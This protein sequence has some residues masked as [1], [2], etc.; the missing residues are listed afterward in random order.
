M[1]APPEYI[2]FPAF[3][4]K[5]NT[6]RLADRDTRPDIRWKTPLSKVL[7]VDCCANRATTV[8]KSNV[9]KL[10]G[11]SGS[12]AIRDERSHLRVGFVVFPVLGT[13]RWKNSGRRA[14]CKSA[15]GNYMR[16]M[17][18]TSPIVCDG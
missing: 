17:C 4:D 10:G 1:K 8:A 2:H 3:A 13:Y 15:T 12:A 16:R 7:L 6:A 14:V 9:Q 11:K 5:Q 18:L